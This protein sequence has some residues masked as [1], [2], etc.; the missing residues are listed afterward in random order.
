MRRR[1]D[2]R[3]AMLDFASVIAIALC[4]FAARSQP[5]QKPGPD[6][7]HAPS[8]AQDLHQEILRLVGEVEREMSAL[9]KF[10]WDRSAAATGDTARD[11]LAQAKA[12]AEAEVKKMERILE[13]ANTPHHDGKPGT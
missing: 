6:P 5:Q 3:P 9:D 2:G 7:D 4:T 11:A 13:L 12:R 1:F 8:Q 10:L